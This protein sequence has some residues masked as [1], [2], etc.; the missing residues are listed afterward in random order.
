ME[1]IKKKE[2]QTT[3]LLKILLKGSL[4][5]VVTRFL[6]RITTTKANAIRGEIFM[7]GTTTELLSPL[8][9]FFFSQNSIRSI[10]TLVFEEQARRERSSLIFF[11][12]VML[13]FWVIYY[14]QHNISTAKT[15]KVENNSTH[16]RR[17]FSTFCQS[18]HGRRCHA[19]SSWCVSDG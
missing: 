11:S 3:D 15:G 17:K 16:S 19:T 5:E 13:W 18:K 14:R 8:L 12:E 9:I 6:E 2:T 1:C 4:D 7:T 10:R